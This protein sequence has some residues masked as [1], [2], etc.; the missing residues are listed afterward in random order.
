M[1]L[2]SRWLFQH[3]SGKVAAASRRLSM[4]RKSGETPLLLWLNQARLRRVVISYS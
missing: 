3:G 2:S 1:R 4:R